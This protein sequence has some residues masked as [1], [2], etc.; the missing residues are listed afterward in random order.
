MVRVL[1]VVPRADARQSDLAASRSSKTIPAAEGSQ[2]AAS[3]SQTYQAHPVKKYLIGLL[4]FAVS[5]A[6]LGYLFYRAAHDESFARLQSQPKGWHL[7]AAAVVVGLVAVSATFFR[8]YLLVRTLHLPI[9]LS[10]AFRLGFIGFL[11][12]FFTFGVLGGDLLKAIFLCRE[13]PEWK[14]EAAK[15]VVVDRMF[16]LYGLFLVAAVAYATLD[17]EA[18]QARSD[19]G[20][21]AIRTVGVVATTVAIGGSIGGLVIMIPAVAASRYWDALARIPKLGD[22]FERLVGALRLYSGRP[23]VMFA[24]VLLSIATHVLITL[25]IY[26]IAEGLPGAHPSALA[27]LTIVPIANLG[28]S[29]PLPGGLGGFELALDFLYRAISSEEVAPRHGFVI[30]LAFRITTLLIATIGMAY[31]LSHKREVDEM[32]HEAEESEGPN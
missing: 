19:Q 15:S 20:L 16:G 29:V 4:K 27:H 1:T 24:S 17:F 28:N 3:V 2:V 9:R 12:N 26:L 6:I 8:W 10:D 22:L 11:F 14:V 18:L 30:A 21:D 31:Y 32:L 7:L 13:H 25:C 5:A 23:G